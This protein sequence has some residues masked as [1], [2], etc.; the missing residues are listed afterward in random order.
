MKRQL[1]FLSHVIFH[2]ADG[3]W[4]MKREK[5][6]S[7]ATCFILLI[8][9]FLTAV[10]KEYAI[11]FVFDTDL[12]VKDSVIFIFALSVMPIL[13][14]SVANLSVT[15]FLDGE[16]TVKDIFMMTCYALIPLIIVN[17]INTILSNLLVINEQT[18]ITILSAVSI[19]WMALL[20]FVGVMEVHNYSVS[21]TVASILLTAVA[22]VII[23]FLVLLFLD[24]ISRIFGFAYSI[25]QEL[26]TRF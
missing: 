14:F 15:T 16:G 13:L 20:L 17:P 19:V 22:M 18:Y 26:Q 21:R 9:Y 23:I 8:L 7:L 11:G 5:R 6:G 12:G 1:K 3:F 10:I 24:M 2:P 25:T 4:D